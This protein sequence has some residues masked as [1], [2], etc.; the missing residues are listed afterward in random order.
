MLRL[1]FWIFVL[2]LALSFFGVSIQPIINSPTGQ[3]NIAFVSILISQVWQWF[4]AY[5][6]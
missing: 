2:L 1:I 6:K 5:I 3:E 4:I